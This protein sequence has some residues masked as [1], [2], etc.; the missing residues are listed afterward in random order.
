MHLRLFLFLFPED[1]NLNHAT[2]LMVFMKIRVEI[3]F[4]N[5]QARVYDGQT[6]LSNLFGIYFINS[7]EK[8]IIPIVFILG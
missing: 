8:Y 3:F 1:K 5:S 2:S 6:D 4:S 7:K